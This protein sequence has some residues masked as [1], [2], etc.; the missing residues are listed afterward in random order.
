MADPELAMADNCMTRA[1]RRKH[2]HADA[3]YRVVRTA[4]GAYGVEVVIP[5]SS[6]AL[7][8]RFA[9]KDVAEAWIAEHKRQV[10]SGPIGLRGRKPTKTP[11]S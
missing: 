10:E 7:V 6:P 9:T 3:T 8:T 5:D 4:D 11:A 2:P 1:A